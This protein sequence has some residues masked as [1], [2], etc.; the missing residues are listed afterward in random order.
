MSVDPIQVAMAAIVG[1]P[2]LSVLCLALPSWFGAKI[3]EGV[4]AAVIG[5][6][7][8]GALLASLGLLSLIVMDGERAIEVP[9]GTWFNVGHYQ[10]EWRLVGDRLSLPF[11]AF[12]AML[13]GLVGA[14]SRRYLHREPGYL[15]F[16][17]M[18]AVFGTGVELVVLAGSLDLIFF[19]WELVGLTSAL[20]IAFYH[21]RT[22]PVEH[23]F[24]AFVTYRACDVGLLGAAVWLHH[25]V[26]HA[27][28]VEGS[29]WAGLVVP[30][31]GGAAM[32]VGFLLL[33]ASMG[34]SAQVPLGGWLPRAMEG[35]T[36]SSAI[37][38]GAIS[39]HLG[40][41]L[42]LRAAPILASAP[43]V[44]YA[45]VA[46]GALTAIHGAMVGNVQ[47][48]IKSSLAYASMTQV[49]LIFVEIGFGLRYF[50]LAHIIGHATLRSLQILRSPSLLHDHHHLEQQ[51]GGHAPPT[52][53]VLERLIPRPVQAWLYRLSLERG[54]FDTLLVD[55]LAGGFRRVM[56]GI[57]AADRA[58]VERIAGSAPANSAVDVPEEQA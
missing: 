57:D 46:V 15:R 38:Y 20:L 8:S 54:Y 55:R 5:T 45:V 26:G 6:A 34:K 39:I 32:L 3:S 22:K 12:S 53:R 9:L 16:A 58:V 18:L 29:P 44:A 17:L 4:V 27:A 49:G 21:D 2:A 50:A 10:F 47:T 51:L 36:N 37:F 13:V 43:I 56:L 42:L 40:P 35:P 52:G 33:W 14:F 30:A 48:D 31:T 7:F 24:R 11:A 1:L 25:S 41:Y 19:G 23:G 28:L